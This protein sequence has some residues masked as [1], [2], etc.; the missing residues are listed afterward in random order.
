M[1]FDRDL[2]RF[3][4]NLEDLEKG[5]SKVI[6]WTLHSTAWKI[7]KEIRKE[8]P[9]ETRLSYGKWGF[10]PAEI[11]GDKIIWSIFND[12]RVNEQRR[13]R[14]AKPL[15]RNGDETY[16]KWVYAKGDG[17]L[18]RPIAPGIIK[19][20]IISATPTIEENFYRILDK[21]LAK[22]GKSR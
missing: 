12:A 13:R 6:E 19:H 20:A 5:A 18:R 15:R 8:W 17:I 22:R 10:E 21:Y 9:I 1:A 7:G 2:E 11:K 16:A 4:Q 3:R 14:G